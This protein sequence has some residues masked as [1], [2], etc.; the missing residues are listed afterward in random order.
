MIISRAHRAGH[1]S[2][3]HQ[4]DQVMSHTTWCIVSSASSLFRSSLFSLF[5]DLLFS[6]D[7]TTNI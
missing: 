3:L 6:P 5:Y 1:D 7:L 2:D 4:Q